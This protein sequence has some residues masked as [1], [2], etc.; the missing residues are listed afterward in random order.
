MVIPFCVIFEIDNPNH[1]SHVGFILYNKQLFTR[2]KTSNVSILILLLFLSRNLG[3][4]FH[5]CFFKKKYV[6]K[7]SA[8]D[9]LLYKLAP[10]QE[11]KSSS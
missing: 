7:N 1:F 2:K 11:K 6:Y 10:R 4:L 8:P 9:S 3:S 5:E